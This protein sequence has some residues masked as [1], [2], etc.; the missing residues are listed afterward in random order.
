MSKPSYD[1]YIQRKVIPKLE[2]VLEKE[3]TYPKN[4][5]RIASASSVQE[6]HD[7]QRGLKGANERKLGQQG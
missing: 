1:L 5:L 6:I 4:R 7:L 2:P 3:G